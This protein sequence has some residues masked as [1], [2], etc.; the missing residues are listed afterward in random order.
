MSAVNH[1]RSDAAIPADAPV[2]AS[3]G[4]PA[5]GRATPYELLL[6]VPALIAANCWMFTSV[7]PGD[8]TYLPS[9]VLNG[10]WWRLFTHPF[11]HVSWYHL[12]LDGGAVVTTYICLSEPRMIKRVLYFLLSAV[13]TTL[14]AHV[15]SPLTEQIGLCGMSGVAYGLVAVCGLEMMGE[16]RLRGRSMV[17]GLLC[18]GVVTACAMVEAITGKGFYSYM[19]CGLLGQPIAIAHAGGVLGG[20]VAYAAMNRPRSTTRVS[21]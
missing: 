18:L 4:T 17:L 21:A 12:L 5:P 2:D 16:D 15:G 20:I 8:L 13:G 14:V 3:A 19:D 7:S 11:V 1:T 9:R 10:E 6:L